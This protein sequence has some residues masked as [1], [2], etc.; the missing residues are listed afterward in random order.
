MDWP[1]ALMET[2]YSTGIRRMEATHLKLYDIDSKRRVVF[3]RC[4][5]GQ[6]D[7]YVPIGER[8]LF[9]IKRYCEAGR[10]QLVTRHDE[11][12]LFLDEYGDP[13]HSEAIGYRVKK[14]MQHCGL[15]VMGS[16]HLFRHAMA[17][18]ML[19]NGADVRFI[20]ALLRHVSLSTT[21]IYTHVAINKLQEIH[22]AT[23]PAKLRRED[24]ESEDRNH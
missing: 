24:T 17:T 18:H 4:G 7:R 11:D 13:Y 16:C 21:Q 8:A 10:L 15:K 9:W 3:I 6:R 5:K 2:L 19:E 22:A 1:R 23:H 14:Y 20:Q 12:T